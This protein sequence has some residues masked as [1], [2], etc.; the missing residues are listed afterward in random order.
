MLTAAVILATDLTGQHVFKE[1]QF[2]GKRKR[3]ITLPFELVHNLI[4]IP[5]FVNDSDTLKFILDSGVSHTLITGLTENDSLSLKYSRQIKLHGL[6]QG[7]PIEALHSFGNKLTLPGGAVGYN[8]DLLIPLEDIFYLSA[9]MGT[10]VN[11]LIGFEIFNSFVV[12]ILYSKRRINLYDPVWYNKKNRRPL[13]GRRRQEK[14]PITIEDRKPY[15]HT[16]VTGTDGKP[17]KAKML[18]DSGASHAISLYANTDEHI[19]VPKNAFRSFLGIGLSGDIYGHIGRIENVK[20]GSFV[21]NEP[22]VSYPDAAAILG[23]LESSKRNGSIGSDLLKRFNVVF[24]YYNKEV[25][26]RPNQEYRKSFKYNMSGIEIT[27][28]FPGLPIYQIAKVRD[29]SPAIKAGIMQGD[30]IIR[31]NGVSVAHFSMNDIIELFQSKPGRKIKLSVQR[32][33]KHYNAEIVLRD[34]MGIKAVD[35]WQ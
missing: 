2:E 32:N 10:K 19:Q 35:R 31:I 1:L 29:N 28:P 22:V 7:E 17:V 8:H 16:E 15:M 3:K 26:L 25:V 18:I 4:I 6:G 14:F 30:Q 21:L 34:M 11:G 12:E 23:V 5:A 27:T 33:N 20:L 13:F 9:S 24:N